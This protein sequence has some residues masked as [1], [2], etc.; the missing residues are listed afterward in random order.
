MAITQGMA[1]HTYRRWS[2]ARVASSSSIKACIAGVSPAAHRIELKSARAIFARSRK[3]P[4]IR[5]DSGPRALTLLSDLRRKLH[6]RVHEG[7]SGLDMK[8]LEPQLS[9]LPPLSVA[10]QIA[11]PAPKGGSNRRQ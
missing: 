11:F 3:A 9:L 7:I 2:N 8:Q 1:S 5:P 10:L 6:R 4:P